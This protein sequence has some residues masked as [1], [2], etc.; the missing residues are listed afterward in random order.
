MK[1]YIIIKRPTNNLKRLYRELVSISTN[2][3]FSRNNNL[4]Y[5]HRLTPFSSFTIRQLLK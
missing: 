3:K 5:W 2:D 4:I 1:K